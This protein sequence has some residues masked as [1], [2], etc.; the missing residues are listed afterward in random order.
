MESKTIP[1]E[2]TMSATPEVLQSKAE[3]TPLTMNAVVKGKDTPD[4]T[5]KEVAD[6]A[7][8]SPT[9]AGLYIQRECQV[10]T[11]VA[12]MLPLPSHLR[13]YDH[14]KELYRVL[15]LV[16]HCQ[17]LS[18]EDAV[19]YHVG[20]AFI[21]KHA[22]ESYR[23]NPK[24]GYKIC[25][26]NGDGLWK[27]TEAKTEF[28]PRRHL[29]FWA[30]ID[31]YL[32]LVDAQRDALKGERTTTEN[33]SR[34]GAAVF[35]QLDVNVGDR[36]KFICE[37]YDFSGL[38]VVCNRHTGGDGKDRLHLQFV[39]NTFPVEKLNLEKLREKAKV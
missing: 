36:V 28:K 8:F 20:V 1:S 4:S 29:R 6:V 39:E 5:W 35:S 37:K 18:G 21:G 32:A 24:Q 17:P 10:G 34:S 33:I 25:G 7:S 16:Q 38:A 30:G 13:C 11:I 26:M 12:I 19:G 14:E 9:G 27:V 2:E 23:E 22:P 3:E 15:G 31:L